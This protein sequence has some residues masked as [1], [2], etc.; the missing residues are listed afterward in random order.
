MSQD[1]ARREWTPRVWQGCN[2]P[3]FLRLLWKNRFAVAPR[4]LYMPVAITTVSLLNSGL[5]ALQ[6]A[7]FGPALRRTTLRHPP[8][9]IV[10]HWRTGTTLLHEF[11][12]LDPQFTSPNTYHCFAPNHFLLTERLARVC[13]RW[14]L[15]SH[16]PMDNM[17]MGWDR[18]Q[19]DEFALCMMGQP[20]PYLTIAFPNHPPQD[21]A[22][23]DVDPLPP[24]Q[25]Q[26][27]KDAFVS[28]L[29]RVSLRDPRRLVLKSP[30]H[31]CRVPT[32]LELFPRAQ[33]L[34]IVRNPYVLFASTKK[35]WQSLYESHG[36]Q[37]PTFAG[38]DEF[39]F[40]TFTHLYDR[41]E[42]GRKLIPPG[43][44]HELKYEDLIA[45][46]VEEVARIYEALRL[47]GFHDLRPRLEA[48][49]SQQA[50]YQTNRYPPL[51][52]DLRDRIRQRWHAVIDRY[53]YSPPPQP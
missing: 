23:L 30:T 7:Y 31:S 6:A 33:F 26:A 32:L 42:A 9:F 37:V 28:F 39:V 41:L 51:D 40:S 46:P 45:R 4:Y 27:W 22:A 48:Y 25:R 24:R 13:L 34:H 36:M 8:L 19:E 10:G 21:M 50:G 16:R 29:H 1:P 18:P 35:L 3:A 2:F 17:P 38:L 14:M 5:Q 44:F 12:T 53:H 47:D 11:L 15:P 20:S 49:W 52:S 43:N